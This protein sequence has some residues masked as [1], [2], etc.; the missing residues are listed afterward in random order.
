MA[1]S[2]DADEII[3]IEDRYY[4][5]ST[6][7][8][9]D[10]R[11]RVLKSGESFA[12]FDRFGDMDTFGPTEFGLYRHGIR[13]LSE[14]LLKINGQ[15]SS[16]L[17]SSVD[18]DNVTFAV[19]QT[20]PDMHDS[21]GT[22]LLHGTLHINRNK[23]M[24][25]A[26]CYERVRIR[27]YGSSLVHLEVTVEFDADFADIFEVR[28][29]SRQKRGTLSG[30]A[31]LG[32]GAL[33]FEYLGLDNRTRRTIVYLPVTPTRVSGGC[34]A[35]DLQ[36]E[37]NE[38]MQLDWTIYCE[39]ADEQLDET[40]VA[41]VVDGAPK[42][43]DYESAAEE[44]HARVREAK[45]AE[46]EIFTANEQFND[47]LNRSRADIRLLC[48]ETEH[49]PYPYAGVP[50]YSTPFGR[51]G[52]I[53]ALQCLWADPSIARGVLGFLSSCQADHE[54]PDTD[55][56][57]GKIVHEIRASEMALLGEVP[58]RRY[59]GTVDA[60]PLFVMLA[61]AYY[62]RTA[63]TDFVASIWPNV[64]RAIEWMDNYGDIDGDGFIEYR[65]RS[66][67]GLANQGWKDSHDS[68]FHADGSPAEGPIALCEVQAY[69]Y[70]AKRAAARL[71]AALNKDA[72]ARR[73]STAAERIRD[74]F[75]EQFWCED[76][77]TYALALD[78]R[79]RQCRVRSSN[80]GHCLYA[81][82]ASK[83]RAE[84]V[85]ATLTSEAGMSG[86]GIR[87]IACGEPRYNPMSYHNGSI[88]P[89][90]NSLIAAGFAR[91]GFME[92]AGNVLQAL[93]EVSLFVDQ[94]RLPEL[95][96]G[97]PKAPGQSP[98]LYPVACSPQ[99]WAAG[100]V[101]LS[102]Q[103]VLGVDVQAEEQRVLF[104][105][106][107]LPPFLSWLRISRLGVGDAEVDLSIVRHDMDVSID[108]TRRSSA[109]TVVA[110]K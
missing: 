38:H 77:S 62:K 96:C 89:H 10:D 83:D 41:H 86:W 15:R 94:H 13:H 17:S 88:W 12:L 25:D 109:A 75:E 27:N 42:H 68:V 103:A 80:A 35:F 81:G 8:R 9:A 52:I 97:L 26:A 44:A 53:T 87:T 19:D 14:L 70:A 30:P 105:S 106:P 101:L 47:W 72:E 3:R 50:W 64:K 84:R 71:A 32:T 48:T 61:G 76:L 39:S 40:S 67:T 104:R 36:I 74:A 79:K 110:V 22:L 85:A 2:Q 82:I 21:S 5:L 51:D 63:D 93:F 59:Y 28:G 58:F 33:A 4:I 7:F 60:T 34:V 6:S 90:D 95:I 23:T 100:A 102:L 37:P 1:D 43:A 11:T 99:A 20:N 107:F 73:L 78:G 98:V 66:R 69:A 65:R 45:A 56:E 31:Q 49:G 46:T 92:Q 16:L 54:D 55:A 29:V 18:E 108:V 91:Y 24:S 57:P